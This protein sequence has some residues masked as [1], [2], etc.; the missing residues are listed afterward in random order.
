MME[1]WSVGVLVEGLMFFIPQYS[2][3]LILQNRDSSITS[4]NLKIA[5]LL[6]LGP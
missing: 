5:F 1:Y 2:S 4:G 6:V 3:T